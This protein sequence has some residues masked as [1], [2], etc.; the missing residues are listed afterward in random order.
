MISI[1]KKIKQLIKNLTGLHLYRRLPRGTEL[2]HDIRV[3]LSGYVV[4]V[5]FDVGANVGQSAQQFIQDFPGSTIYCFEPAGDTFQQL[6]ENFQNQ[7]QVYCFQN[8]MGFSERKGKLVHQGSSRMFFIADPSQEDTLDQNL[9]FE[10]VSIITLDNFCR[11]N[12]IHSISYLKIDTEGADLDVLK[13]A[14]TMLTDHRIDLVQVEA[15]M[16]CN[17]KR[18]VPFEVVKEF[19]EQKG[20]FLFA[21]YEQFHESLTD[22]P[23][24]RRTNPV[25]ISEKMIR[26]YRK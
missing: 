26:A 17:N 8:A 3:S 13:G 21:I 23:H 25:F 22:E 11:N 7:K 6:L 14:E 15:G 1:K 16:N 5:V 20:Y 19:L 10:E 4:D 9:N 2:L 18:H 12:K 24:L